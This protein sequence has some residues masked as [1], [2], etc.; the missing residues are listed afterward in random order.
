MPR[1]HSV[2]LR[3]MSPASL[4]ELLAIAPVLCKSIIEA[5]GASGV[6]FLQ[7]TGASSGQAVFHT[8]FHFIPRRENDGLGLRWNAG[9]YATGRAEMLQAKITRLIH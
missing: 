2:D 3:D 1:E 9:S 4:G 6:N 5:T 7:N 8:H